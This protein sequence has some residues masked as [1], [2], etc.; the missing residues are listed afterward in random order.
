MQDD[1]RKTFDHIDNADI[2]VYEIHG[3]INGENFLVIYQ[4]HIDEMTIIGKKSMVE[5]K[6]KNKIGHIFESGIKGNLFNKKDLQ[7]YV[8]K[9]YQHGIF[10]THNEMDTLIE[11]ARTNMGSTLSYIA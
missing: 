3:D 9:I 5:D 1:Q 4:P 7:E 10:L 6:I 2:S 11:E 8:S